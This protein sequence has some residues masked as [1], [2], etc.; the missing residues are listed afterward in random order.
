MKQKIPPDIAREVWEGIEDLAGR[1]R[2]VSATKVELLDIGAVVHLTCTFERSE[3]IIRVLVNS[4]NKVEWLYYAPSSAWL[5]QQTRSLIERA[6]AGDFAGASSLFDPDMRAALPPAVFE[7]VWRSVEQRAGKLVA[8]ENVELTQHGEETWVSLATVQ[9]TRTKQIV[10]IT[11]NAHDIVI[12]LNVLPFTPPWTPPAYADMNAIVELECRVGDNPALP[13]TLAMPI[14]QGNLPAIVLVHGS[15]PSDRDET[16]GGTKVFR[17][18][19]VGL[20]S[21]GIAVL[22]Y[23]KRSRYSPAGVITEKEEVIDGASAAIA[24]LRNTERVDSKRVFVL[25]HSQ[26]GA[27][28]P[29]IAKENPGVAGLVVLAGPTRSLQDIL[30]DQFSYFVSLQPADPLLA[31]KVEEA[32][33]FK[34]RVEDPSLQPSDIVHLPTGGEITGAYFLFQRGY[35]PV[36]TAKALRIPLL[37]LQGERDYQVTMRDLDG[38]RQG[39]AGVANAT[40]KTYPSMNHLF[41]SGAGPS[42]P[43]E[44]DQPGHVHEQV[45][46]DIAKW[47]LGDA[48]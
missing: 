24:L 16:V 43:A 46:T 13:G 41:V 29:R 48:R 20:A 5:E 4:E 30:L 7:T 22:R 45:V 21:K 44:Y 12:G 3:K 36:A 28:G 19:A 40:I 33:A 18:L 17:D 27:L 23:E 35:D 37:V 14:H 32:R 6:N 39:I 31:R 11:Y 38:W 25:G 9:F 2:G 26:G 10:S 34:Q 8:I 47:I 15:G 1:F 42:T